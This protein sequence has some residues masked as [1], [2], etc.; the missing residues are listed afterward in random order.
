[1]FVGDLVINYNKYSQS[2]SLPSPPF[3]YKV[4]YSL[5][6]SGER[7]GDRGFACPFRGKGWEKGLGFA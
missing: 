1:M 6:P 5:A 2:N 4:T 3:I 7:V